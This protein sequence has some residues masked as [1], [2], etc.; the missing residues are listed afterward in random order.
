MQ[1]AR[2]VRVPEG[3]GVRSHRRRPRWVFAAAF[4]G[5]FL[6]AYLAF[7]LAGSLLLRSHESFSPIAETEGDDVFAD[8]LIVKGPSAAL[9]VEH[10]PRLNPLVGSDFL[11]FVWFKLREPLGRE[12]RM[13]LMGKFDPKSKD[14]VGYSVALAGGPDGVRPQVYWQASGGAGKWYNYAAAPI[15]PKHW[16]LLVF[17]F[18]DSRYLGV[19]L[20]ELREEAKPLVLGGYSVDPGPLPDSDAP[21]VVG[22][23]GTNPFRGRIGPF[24]V[25]QSKSFS[26]G[27]SG[28]IAALAHEPLR[29]P[30]VI[31]PEEISL[32]ASPRTD[33]GPLGLP[34]LHPRAS[35][36]AND[37]DTDPKEPAQP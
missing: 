2:A 5:A 24:G 18:R 33:R 27:L 11:F 25:I 29:V 37:R 4:F 20:A 35:R 31:S 16:Y 13:Y 21:L 28:F 6:V 10:S 23:F 34:I 19:H 14:R 26:D 8:A 36:A 3:E 22:G 1:G 30:S 12:E 17:T 9:S 32:W 7:I 15:K